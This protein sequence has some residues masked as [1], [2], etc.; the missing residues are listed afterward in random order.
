MRS[1]TSISITD[2]SSSA[3]TAQWL[4]LEPFSVTLKETCIVM[5]GVTSRSL[6]SSSSVVTAD[7]GRLTYSVTLNSLAPGTDY[8][9]V[10]HCWNK[11]D[12]VGITSEEMP[13]RTSDSGELR[14]YIFIHCLRHL[15]YIYIYIYHRVWA[16]ES[17][18]YNIS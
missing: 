17:I 16:C 15:Y 3:V 18:S 14:H 8:K 6:D 1:P 2:T 7:G 13:F 5:F 4:F 10:I 12:S 11:F 9:Y